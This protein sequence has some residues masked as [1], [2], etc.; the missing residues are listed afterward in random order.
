MSELFS[1]R[2]RHWREREGLTQVEAGRR[3]GV[4]GRYLVMIENGDKQVEPSSSLAQL[5]A[6]LEGRKGNSVPESL[7]VMEEGLPYKGRSLLKRAREAAGLSQRALAEAVGY[8]LGT[9]QEI[10]EGR[11]QMGEKMARKVAA[12]LGID[13]EALMAGADEPPQRGALNGDFGTMPEVD[14]GPG[15]EG[16]RAKLVPLLSMAECGPGSW[17]DTGYTGQ[18]FLALTPKDGR[19]FA[20]KL[21]GDSMTPRHEAGDVALVYPGSSPRNGDLVVAKLTEEEGGDVM[22]KLWQVSGD[23]VTLSS[24]NPAY[25]PMTF[26]RRAFAWV[27]PVAAVTKVLR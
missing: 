6:L 22:F 3:L 20:V 14:M 9:Y 27:Y 24:Y 11:S 4:S 26:L 2:L 23:R 13:P 12:R 18:G 1:H 17:E 19:A 21:S 5:F 7:V 8:T 10:E 16:Q 15:M 25:P